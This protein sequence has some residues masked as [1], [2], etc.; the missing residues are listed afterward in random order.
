MVRRR[1]W[2]RVAALRPQ[3]APSDSSPQSALSASGPNSSSSSTKV[4]PL[5]DFCVRA[6]ERKDAVVASQNSGGSNRDG[7]PSSEESNGVKCISTVG[8]T[9]TGLGDRDVG[10]SD[11]EMK[12]ASS[13]SRDEEENAEETEEARLLEKYDRA[14]LG[15]GSSQHAVRDSSRGGGVA[16]RIEQRLHS[17]DSDG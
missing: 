13:L 16:Q 9:K 5:H 4:E 7:K 15:K 11:S 12:K 17:D 14:I 8:G 2:T 10:G 1:R 3:S 6:S